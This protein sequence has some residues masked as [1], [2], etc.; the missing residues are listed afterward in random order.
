[1]PDLAADKSQSQTAPQLTH[2]FV[3]MQ[4]RHHHSR[5]LIMFAD[6]LNAA[7]VQMRRWMGVGNLLI[8]A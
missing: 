4:R 2:I 1:M 7:A 3:Q 5:S 6:S 8:L